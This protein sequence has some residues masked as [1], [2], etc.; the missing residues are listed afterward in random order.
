MKSRLIFLFVVQLLTAG[1]FL[2]AMAKNPDRLFAKYQGFE[3]VFEGKLV[4]EEMVKIKSTTGGKYLYPK[5]SVR[6]D[7]IWKGSSL[8]IGQ[9]VIGYGWSSAKVGDRY[10]FVSR[11][12]KFASEWSLPVGATEVDMI[13][14]RTN[15]NANT[16]WFDFIVQGKTE[17]EKQQRSE[18][19]F[20][21]QRSKIIKKCEPLKASPEEAGCL[22]GLDLWK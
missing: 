11:P 4:S 16:E 2:T 8:K 1:F 22:G 10:I 7:K 21:T 3:N 9:D 20:T 5:I 13:S 15:P 6:V 17:K 14:S 19:F 12:H 18:K